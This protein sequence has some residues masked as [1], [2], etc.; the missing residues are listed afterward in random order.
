MSIGQSVAKILRFFFDF[1]RCI[2]L[3]HIWITHSEY[4]WVSITAKFSYDRC[5]SF[6]N[7]NISI[8]GTFGWKKPI[9]APKI[10]VLIF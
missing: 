9:Y 4:L 5:G 8:F 7:M 2:C 6:Y 1:S 10:G 3:G